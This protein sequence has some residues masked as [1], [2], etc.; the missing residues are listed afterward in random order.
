[1]SLAVAVVLQAFS[2]SPFGQSESGDVQ[3]D[4]VGQEHSVGH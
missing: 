3:L 4:A 1:M 2:A